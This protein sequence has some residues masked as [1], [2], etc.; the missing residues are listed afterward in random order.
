M[1]TREARRKEI[2]RQRTIFISHSV[3]MDSRS[4]RTLPKSRSNTRISVL[5]GTTKL[6]SPTG[7]TSESTRLVYHHGGAGS[8]HGGGSGGSTAGSG[9]SSSSS[10]RS[11]A[12]SGAAGGGR[13]G[14][15]GSGA[16]SYQAFAKQAA[17]SHHGPY[18][19]P[20]EDCLH[21]GVT[22]L[23]WCMVAWLLGFAL[24]ALEYTR[25]WGHPAAPQ[26][27]R[28]GPGGSPDGPSWLIFAPF[29]LGDLLA[30]V[31][32]ARVVGKVASVR[33]ATPH[34]SRNGMRRTSTDS[35]DR[36]SGSL[37]ELGGGNDSS[38]VVVPVNLDYFPLIQRVVVTAVGAFVVLV[39]VVTEQVLVCLWWGGHQKG[40]GGGGGGGRGPGPFVLAAPVLT[41]EGLC[42]LRVLI[43]RTEGLLS[44][45]T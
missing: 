27:G 14:G 29:W 21:A 43:L 11:Q 45:L 23:G 12:R 38:C 41:L 25:T 20:V 10:S 34:R 28:H 19:N 13:G 35:R 36:S 16:G 37:N 3:A 4:L 26:S 40:Q 1:L 42:L 39:L 8:N 17:A 7:N 30:V 5:T 32:L 44:G 18:K 15:Y 31:V 2:L 6:K 22:G 9:R 24:L 33:F